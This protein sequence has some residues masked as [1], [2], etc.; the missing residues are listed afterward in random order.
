MHC[1]GMTPLLGLFGCFQSVLPLFDFDFGVQA[2]VVQRHSD[3]ILVSLNGCGRHD[4]SL[5]F[6]KPWASLEEGDE[7]LHLRKCQA[8]VLMKLQ[9]NIDSA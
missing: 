4:S 8:D 6:D 5:S 1:P 3:Q 9:N 7:G 2:K